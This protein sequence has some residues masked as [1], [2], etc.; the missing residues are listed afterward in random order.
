ME[1]RVWERRNERGITLEELGKLTQISRSTLNRIENGQISPRLIHL[2]KI[3]EA[4]NV[5]IKDLVESE[6]L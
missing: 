6:Y 2:E 5:K 3:A 1:V 4:L